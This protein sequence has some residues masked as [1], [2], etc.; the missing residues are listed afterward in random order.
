MGELQYNPVN[1]STVDSVTIISQDNSE[2]REFLGDIIESQDRPQYK[3]WASRHPETAERFQ[4]LAED[5]LEDPESTAN[6][7]AHN[8]LTA[9]K[10]VCGN[11]THSREDDFREGNEYI[12]CWENTPPNSGRRPRKLTTDDEFAADCESFWPSRESLIDHDVHPSLNRQHFLQRLHDGDE[13]DQRK[14]AL[15]YAYY[16]SWGH[17]TAI[18]TEKYTF[19][20]SREEAMLRHLNSEKSQESSDHGEEGREFEQ[21]V[22][23]F[24]QKEFDLPIKDRVF[25]IEFADGSVGFKEMD[26]HT[27]VNSE[28]W[29]AELYTQ[30]S[31]RH[32][33]TQLDDYTQLFEI[34]TGIEPTAHLVTDQ[35]HRTEYDENDEPQEVFYHEGDCGQITCSRFNKLLREELDMPRE[36]VSLGKYI[37]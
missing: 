15:K 11:C 1:F 14:A 36:S 16:Q 7:L 24:I 17:S 13:S 35:I 31:P 37:D 32:K 27:E 23:H 10:R 34:A 26:L 3:R 4:Q 20:P 6:A 19:N 2:Y 9:P 29:I 28:P 21:F 18:D 33:T 5:A 22:L 30:Y 25:R 8:I 12:V